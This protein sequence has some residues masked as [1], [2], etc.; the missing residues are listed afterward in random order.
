M[1]KA[2]IVVALVLVACGKEVDLGDGGG[3]GNSSAP[4]GGSTVGMA[5]CT[6]FGCPM[7]WTCCIVT[8]DIQACTTEVE[9]LAT[10]SCPPAPCEPHSPYGGADA[11]SI[12]EDAGQ[13]T[14]VADAGSGSVGCGQDECVPGQD[15]CIVTIDAKTCATGLQCVWG[16]C[17]PAPCD[18]HGD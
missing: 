15:C 18:P 3:G 10:D 1:R 12:A 9:C 11:G 16:G 8:T 17:P 5:S 4:S 2:A 14:P 7:G 13:V 6:E